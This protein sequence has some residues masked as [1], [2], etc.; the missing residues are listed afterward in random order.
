MNIL[1]TYMDREQSSCIFL[2][3]ATRPK[4]HCVGWSVGRSHFAFECANGHY[5]P[6]PTARDSAAVYTALLNTECQ[7]KSV[8]M[9]GPVSRNIKS[10]I[11]VANPHNEQ[12]TGIKN[13]QQGYRGCLRLFELSLENDVK[14][15]H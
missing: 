9:M 10:I 13:V 6:C 11:R 15:T 3:R 7:Q 8:K 2:S 14:N 5:C 4:S 1:H 12:K